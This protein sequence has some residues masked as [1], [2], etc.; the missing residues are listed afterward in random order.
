MKGW[1][2]TVEQDALALLNDPTNTTKVQEVVTLSNHT[3]NG[4]DTNGDGSIDPVPGEGG[5][6]TAYYH[7]QL[8]AAL[9]LAPGS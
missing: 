9:V 7:A 6:A 4:V 5:A 3:L 1:I 8:T 2:T